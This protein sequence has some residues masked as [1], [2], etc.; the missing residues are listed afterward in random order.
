L[1]GLKRAAAKKKNTWGDDL[2][3][4]K[5]LAQSAGCLTMQELLLLQI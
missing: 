3:R 4:W 5:E 1:E 2:R